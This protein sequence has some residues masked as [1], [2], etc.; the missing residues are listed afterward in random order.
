MFFVLKGQHCQ[1]SLLHAHS[2]WAHA[3]DNSVSVHVIYFDPSKAFDSNSH[4]KSIYKLS[5]YGLKISSNTLQ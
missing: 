5:Q 2:H 3:M 4:L 1:P